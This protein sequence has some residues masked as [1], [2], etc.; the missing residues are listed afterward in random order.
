[1]SGGDV[2]LKL[3]VPR[4]SVELG[5]PVAES[6]N[7]PAREFADGGFDLVDGTRAVRINQRRFQGKRGSVEERSI[8]TSR[9]ESVPRG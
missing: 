5:E 7:L 1:M 6:Q 8:R 2:L 9:T 3:F 4:G